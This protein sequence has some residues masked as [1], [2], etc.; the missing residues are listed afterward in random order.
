[1]SLWSKI[2]HYP[3]PNTSHVGSRITDW[4]SKTK[5]NKPVIVWRTR[6]KKEMNKS[7]RFA[8]YFIISITL[9]LI[10]SGIKSLISFYLL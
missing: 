4:M 10:A 7:Q 3:I 1:M 6:T 8:G 5:E 2:Y 9:A